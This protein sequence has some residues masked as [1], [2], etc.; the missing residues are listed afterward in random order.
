MKISNKFVT[1]LVAGSIGT[2]AQAAPI[3]MSD[4]V[5]LSTLLTNQSTTIHYDA[6]N[7]LAGQGLTRND[8]QAAT[9]VV[10]GLSDASYATSADPYGAYFQTGTGYHTYYVPYTY[11]A[12]GYY[13]SSYSC[14]WLGRSTCYQQNS[15]YY[16]VTGYYSVGASD[17]TF[18]EQRNIEHRDTQDTMTV[19]VGNTSASAVD[20]VVGH[21]QGAYSFPQYQNRY[22][23]S[24]DN[25]YTYYSQERDVYDSVTGPLLA[26]L[27]LSAL[28]L[29]TLRTS[30]FIDID[31]SALGHFT[32][33]SLGISMT[34]EASSSA[35]P[36]P[37]TLALSLTGILALAAS[38]R[39][40]KPIRP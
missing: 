29:Q 5:T 24:G 10:Y 1:S 31:V 33:Q 16:P 27:S 6:T 9:L 13:T 37:A 15:Y 11:Y 7:L 2:I 35:V 17:Y 26:S 12:Q 3:T 23:D 21:S 4:T 14:G 19:S 18:M 22:Y 20:S 38:R 34:G 28:N 40:K 25:S 32:L 8:V 39:R 30:G 36:E